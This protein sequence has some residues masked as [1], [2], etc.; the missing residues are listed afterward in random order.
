M[1]LPIALT[2]TT[3]ALAS[4]LRAAFRVATLAR[5]RPL[6]NCLTFRLILITLI[7]SS[8]TYR[9]SLLIPTINIA[10]LDALGFVTF[11]LLYDYLALPAFLA[12]SV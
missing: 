10:F 5:F 8:S 2:T 1:A 9:C 3:L 7:L 12:T 11:D 6:R 4:A